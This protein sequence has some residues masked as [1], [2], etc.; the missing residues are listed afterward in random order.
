MAVG[1]DFDVFFALD[2]G[3]LFPITKCGRREANQIKQLLELV[4]IHP[5]FLSLSLS[6]SRCFNIQP[7]LVN[8]CVYFSMTVLCFHLPTLTQHVVASIFALLLYEAFKNGLVKR[9][10]L[11][12]DTLSHFVET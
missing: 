11:V 2:L 7:S 8:M 9:R 1:K 4:A 3:R 12:T 5:R 6:E 10:I